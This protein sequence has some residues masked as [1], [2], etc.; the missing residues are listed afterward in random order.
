MSIIPRDPK[1]TSGGD[2]AYKYIATTTDTFTL[3]AKTEVSDGY[4]CIDQTSG[5]GLAFS[6]EPP[7]DF[8]GW[9]GGGGGASLSQISSGDWHTCAVKTDDTVWCWGD[10]TDG[11][12]GINNTTAQY[13]PVQVLGAGGS[14]T[15]TN[16]SQTIAGDYHTCAVKIDGTAWCW[17]R[18]SLGQLGINNT[19]AQ[20]A[21]VQVLGV[22]GSGNLTNVRQISVGRFHTCVVKTDDTVWCWGNNSSGQLGINNTTQQYAPVQVLG[23]GGSGI[24][25]NVSQIAAGRSQTCAVKTDD[26]VW[27]WGGNTDGQLG[28]NNTIQ[29]NAPVQV[30]GVG[31]SGNLTNVSQVAVGGNVTC[32][33]KNDG[34]VWCWGWN[35]YGQLGTNN[36]ISQ[37]APVQVLG[38]GGSGTLT[39]ASQIAVGGSQTCAVKTD[40][41][42]WC[43]GTNGSGQLGTNNTTDQYA[44]VQV[45]G[46]GGSG[47]LTNVSQV[48]AGTYHSCAIKTDN[49]AWC[50]G[51][52]SRGQ[53]GTNNTT[54]QNAPIEPLF[55]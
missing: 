10:N 49:T 52:N 48:A 13:A 43:W 53:L 23:A 5:G 46:V 47:N 12:L 36:N 18:N 54:Q 51:I 26:T 1:Y 50:W 34:T 33:V 20:Y 41:T 40:N 25:T 24:L 27:C 7:V 9:G 38:A 15:L 2:F 19:T 44:P 28:I 32:A 35:Y 3:C 8:G 39:G 4:A 22:G 14:G 55:P 37:N 45:L 30:L 31:G 42:A 11:R 29:Q 17:G 6:D 21:P 16:V